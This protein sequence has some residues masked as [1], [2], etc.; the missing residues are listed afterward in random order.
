MRRF[1]AII[2]I[3]ALHAAG[4]QS[5]QGAQI[6]VA[7]PE[8]TD[9][10][11]LAP[12]DISFTKLPESPA[13]KSEG[14]STNCEQTTIDTQW[15]EKLLVRDTQVVCGGTRLKAQVYVDLKQSL[16][17]LSYAALEVTA[18]CWTPP[19]KNQKSQHGFQWA[20]TSCGDFLYSIDVLYQGAV[21]VDTVSKL[22]TSCSSTPEGDG[23][24]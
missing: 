3:V 10:E 24:G 17:K 2:L 6:T 7:S 15:G 14:M 23:V 13:V 5:A 18:P 16:K 8:A 1:L 22:T 9:C 11:T 4:A 12:I 21:P 19:V 20:Y